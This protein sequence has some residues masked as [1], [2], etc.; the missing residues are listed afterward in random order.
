[1]A[2]T[3]YTLSQI[4]NKVRDLLSDNIHYDTSPDS[5][6]PQTWDDDQVKKAINFAIKE[7]CRTT[8]ASY[9]EATVSVDSAGKAT[10]P[11]D[12]IEIERV[13]Y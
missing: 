9:V 12:W 1:M 7:Y 5:L 6:S 2:I 8:K 11:T 13:I 10:I 3:S 4:K